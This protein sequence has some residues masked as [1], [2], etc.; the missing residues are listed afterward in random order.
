[1][2]L[3]FYLEGGYAK[4]ELWSFRGNIWKKNNDIKSPLYWEFINKKIYIN[5]FARL[6]DIE[7]I[8]NF[9]IINISWYEAEAFCKWKGVRLITESEWEYLATNGSKTLYPWGDDEERLYKCN[10]NYNNKW[11]MSVK[12]NS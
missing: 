1:M 2:F 10:V 5:Y 8:Y 11:I 3:Q 4:D 9:P 7:T 12:N 6:I